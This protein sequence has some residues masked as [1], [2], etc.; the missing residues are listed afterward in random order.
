MNEPARNFA[1]DLPPDPLAHLP[2][3]YWKNGDISFF[4]EKASP[5]ILDYCRRRLDRDPDLIGDF[6]VYFYERAALCLDRYK[7][8]RHLPFTGFLAVYLRHEFKNFLRPRRRYG[9]QEHCSEHIESLVG[10][11]HS[12][13]VALPDPKDS[14]TVR[15]ASLLNERL[16]NLEPSSRLP[17]KL[18]HGIILTAADLKYL[19]QRSGDPER[20][21]SF[22]LEFNR[23]REKRLDRLFKIRNR[24]AF[25]NYLLHS[26]AEKPHLRSDS[27]YW[28]RWK[29]RAGRFLEDPGGVFT[30]SEIGEFLKINRTSVKR[31]I[32]RAEREL[33]EGA[34]DEG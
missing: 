5:W 22:L 9:I 10:A 7:T 12:G 18:F 32:M 27:S 33:R 29:A 8:R 11:F 28:K 4:M 20:A 30:L 17:L 21:S 25:L 3:E 26:D 19:V 15:F 1:D 13:G 6:Y 24:S 2:G 14:S 34:R 23:R 16:E 31:R